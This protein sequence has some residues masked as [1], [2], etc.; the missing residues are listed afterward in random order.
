MVYEEGGEVLIGSM[1]GSIPAPVQPGDYVQLYTI[2]KN[3]VKT[4]LLITIKPE[5][6]SFYFFLKLANGYTNCL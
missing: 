3:D 2:G 6:Q 5:L 4:G 1:A